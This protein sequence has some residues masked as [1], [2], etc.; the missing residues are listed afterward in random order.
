MPL[1]SNSA[2]HP[3]LPF[4]NGHIQTIYPALLRRLPPLPFERQ[5]IRTPDGDFLDLDW[6]QHTPKLLPPGSGAQS[7]SL[8]S[9]SALRGSLPASKMQSHVTP[10]VYRHQ[11]PEVSAAPARPLVIL[12][13]GLEGSSGQTYI[14][15]MA[16]AFFQG[17]WDVLAWNF[18]GCS[19]TP[20]LKLRS[21]HSGATDDL[22]T[23]ISHASSLTPPPASAS[24]ASSSFP[25]SHAPYTHSSQATQPP[26]SHAKRHR[27]LPTRSAS[28]RHTHTPS[29]HARHTQHPPLGGNNASPTP[30]IPTGYRRIALI[31]FSLGGNIV[32][33]YLGQSSQN[34]T[35]TLHS[36]AHNM[37]ANSLAH[38]PLAQITGAVAISVP[39]DLAGS[40]AVLERRSNRVY[41]ERFLKTLRQKIRDKHQTF[42]DKISINGLDAIR[43]FREFDDRYTAPLHGFTSADHYWHA[44]SCLREME[45]IRTPALLLNAEDDPFLSP[46]CFPTQI[47]REHPALHLEVT[48]HGGHVGFVRHARDGQYYSEWR[49]LEFLNKHSG[50]TSEVV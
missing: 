19:G 7:A 35:T 40:T 13:H 48:R 50:F 49:A 25:A 29:S 41:M 43:T 42:P 47:A 14:R 5:R 36:G 10:T 9:L 17:G 20:N 22:Q 45:Y 2:Y 15:G 33:K 37:R 23:V 8:G 30:W 28:V 21:Y 3:V 11:P 26:T 16:R 46:G 12:T 18:R 6:L 38:P 34:A 39:C 4:R 31:G 32:L 1:L 24:G 27:P 44:C